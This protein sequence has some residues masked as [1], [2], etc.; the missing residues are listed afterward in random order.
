M[1]VVISFEI[2]LYFL[3]IELVHFL[4]ED[5]IISGKFLTRALDLCLNQIL[6]TNGYGRYESYRMIST[7]SYGGFTKVSLNIHLHK[8]FHFHEHLAN[9]YD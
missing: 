9:M 7:I 5:F 6:E 8:H 3:E 1:M 2:V 4:Q